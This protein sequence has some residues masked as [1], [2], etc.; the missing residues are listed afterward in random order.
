[1]KQIKENANKLAR[2][3]LGMTDKT[4][5]KVT[6]K[7]PTLK[8]VYNPEV[9]TKSDIKERLR[10]ENFELS[11]KIL[12]KKHMDEIDRLKFREDEIFDMGYYPGERQTLSK[13]K[14]GRR[15]E[16]VDYNMKV[17]SKQTIGV[18]GHELP[19]FA[20]SEQYKEFWK[21]REGW[22]E[23]PNYQSQVELL[24]N[25]KFWKKNE[26]L[27]IKD[28]TEDIPDID[29]FKKEYFPM[30]K[31]GEI[32]LKVNGLNHFKNFDPNNP[33]PIDIDNIKRKHIYRWTTLVNQFCSQ[34]F[35]NGRYFDSLPV[36]ANTPLDDKAMYSSFNEDGIFKSKFGKE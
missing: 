7:D 30:N 13:L 5:I 26:D 28:H 4:D 21:F 12:S 9:R 3:K 34:K 19:K 1:M 17:F 2:Q 6:D 8:Y 33:E 14:E 23:N 10:K 27:K 35:K 11:K 18:H 32:I 36:A 25:Q 20:D 29:D 24:E 22:V 31:K 15:K 16:N